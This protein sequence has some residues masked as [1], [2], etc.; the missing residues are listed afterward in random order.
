MGNERVPV[1]LQ[2]IMGMFLP[3]LFA[4]GFLIVS[5]IATGSEPEPGASPGAGLLL[6]SVVILAVGTLVQYRFVR[7]AMVVGMMDRA[8][9]PLVVTVLTALGAVAGV[10]MMS[11]VPSGERD[12]PMP[13]NRNSVTFDGFVALAIIWAAAGA[14][15]IFRPRRLPHL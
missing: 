8:A 3:A 11:Y 14:G 5:A 10:L 2:A 13:W 12:L 1:P 6:I 7:R 4:A 9:S 15:L